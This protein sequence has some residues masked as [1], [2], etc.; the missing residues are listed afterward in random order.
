MNIQPL[1]I[2][3]DGSRYWVV[4]FETAKKAVLERDLL[5]DKA[6]AHSKL[7]I[8]TYNKR[9]AEKGADNWGHDNPTRDIIIKQID[10]EL[11]ERTCPKYLTY[12]VPETALW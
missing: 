1:V 6:R 5:I 12:I 9:C 10:D 8:S 3:T 2:L 4:P 7:W 11:G